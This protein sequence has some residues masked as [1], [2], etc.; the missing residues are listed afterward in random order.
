MTQKEKDLF[1]LYLDN[2]YAELLKEVK[3]LPERNIPEKRCK[4]YY[5]NLLENMLEESNKVLLEKLLEELRDDKHI[6]NEKENIISFFE[7][8]IDNFNYASFKNEEFARKKGEKLTLLKDNK[9][10]NKEKDKNKEKIP[11]SIKEV[12]D[13]LTYVYNRSVPEI[14]YAN[15]YIY[16]NLLNENLLTLR[17]KCKSFFSDIKLSYKKPLEFKE[18]NLKKFNDLT[19]EIFTFYKYIKL[20]YIMLDE[21]EEV[22]ELFWAFTKSVLYSYRDLA[23]EENDKL[24]EINEEFKEEIK[25]TK[26]ELKKL[27]EELKKLNGL[28]EFKGTKEIRELK[29]KLKVKI[30]EAEEL[31]TEKI[32]KNEEEIKNIKEKIKDIKEQKEPNKLFNF[33]ID[34]YTLDIITKYSVPGKLNKFISNTTVSDFKFTNDCDIVKKFINICKNLDDKKSHIFENYYH[35]L[36]RAEFDDE[37]RERFINIIYDLLIS[38]EPDEGPEFGE[39]K[40]REINEAFTIKNRTIAMNKLLDILFNNRRDINTI[41]KY[42]QELDMSKYV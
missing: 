25:R 22:E 2:D 30:K 9:D 11:T 37:Q 13:N 20:N 26:E 38:M 42:A 15:K 1:K 39:A 10:E 23:K 3:A 28:I 29:N 19:I 40:I 36:T 41:K 18:D 16:N 14:K 6:K 31:K 17:L 35:I 7:T 32:K 21:F 27:K 24:K 12:R 4:A 5:L 33:Y 34:K 8:F